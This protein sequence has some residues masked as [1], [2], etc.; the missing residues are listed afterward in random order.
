VHGISAF[1]ATLV[2]DANASTA[3]GT[4]GL[5]TAAVANLGA[6]AGNALA[7]DTVA[8]KGDLLVATGDNALSRLAVGAVDGNAL[9]PDTAATTGVSWSLNSWAFYSAGSYVYPM[10]SD[11]NGG[12]IAP[13][14]SRLALQLIYLSARRPIDRLAVFCTSGGSA[15][16]TVRMGV[17]GCLP[18]GRPDLSTGPLCEVGGVVATGTGALAGV[19]SWTPPY[20]GWFWIGVV[21]QGG[22]STRPTLVRCG[23]GVAVV[24]LAQGISQFI[25]TAYF[26]GSITGALPNSG[27]LS[28]TASGNLV[29]TMA[30]WQ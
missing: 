26:L 20:V 1:G 18:T 8:A 16:A 15:G 12:A 19:V 2:D 22:A 24:P 13:P 11:P 28:E 17:Y 14:E 27:T 23:T 25:A 5:G 10:Q 7:V 9:V 3:R 29:Q 21:V 6:A 30:R 4:L